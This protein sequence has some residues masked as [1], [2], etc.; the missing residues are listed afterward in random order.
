MQHTVFIDGIRPAKVHDLDAAYDLRST[1]GTH[2]LPND[3]VK[4]PC[5]FAIAIPE[6]CVGLVCSR[7]GLAHKHGVF[8]L[9]APGVIDPGYQGEVEVVLANIGKDEFTI[10]PG[11]R[12]AQL[13]IVQ[14]L[15]AKLVYNK[16]A[17]SEETH[18]ASGGFGS[19]GVR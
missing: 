6:G 13:L 9:N 8:V 19:T 7:G 10:A 18:R 15:D 2:I 14:T 4:V 3:R 16:N 5:G 12:I 17:F 1:Y 11:D